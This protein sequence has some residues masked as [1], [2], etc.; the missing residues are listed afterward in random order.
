MEKE[1]F[2]GVDVGSVSTDF[3]LIDKALNIKDKVYLRNNGDPIKS[4]C[5]GMS[6][7]KIPEDGKICASGTTGSG[8]RL[9]SF[10]IGADTVKNEIIAHGVAALKVCPDVKTV[11]EIGGQDSK[12]IFFDN[13][14]ITDFNMNTVCAA[15]TGSFLDR[16]AG[17]LGV[18][19]EEIGELAL[20]SHSPVRIAGR[21]AVFAESD[22]IHKQQTG[23]RKEDIL[24]GLCTAL[25]RGYL[26]NLS[27]G[28]KIETP[29]L[30]QGGVAANKGIKAAFEEELQKELIVPKH[31]DVMGAYGAAVIAYENYL[32]TK[33][34]SYRGKDFSSC[35][36]ES[37]NITCR[38]C[39]NN[40]S[41]S[42]L[43]CNG[44]IVG[45]WGSRCGRSFCA[46]K[47]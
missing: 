5:D 34:T 33:K 4:V 43:K 17:R 41:V 25:A 29:I 22:M 16:T 32:K 26:N 12:I 45:E 39:D 47:H 8:R 15:G 27:K 3:V 6:R 14:I 38:G 37:E 42:V 28:R 13:G 9:A 1:F 35:E 24:K 20:Q 44:E 7:R 46:V 19:V 31:Y 11:I 23:C 2:L 18:G 36:W 21:C 10:I 30:F 40:C